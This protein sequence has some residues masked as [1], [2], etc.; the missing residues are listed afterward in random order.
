MGHIVTVGLI[1]TYQYWKETF[2]QKERKDKDVSEAF[3]RRWIF[4]A[5]YSVLWQ[6]VDWKAIAIVSEEHNVSLLRVKT[7]QY[8]SYTLVHICQ[9]TLRHIKENRNTKVVIC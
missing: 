3:G 4:T 8:I 7:K 6:R 2:H 5:W 1:N 9:A